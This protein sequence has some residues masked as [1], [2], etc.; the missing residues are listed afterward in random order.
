M[1]QADGQRERHGYVTHVRQTSRMSLKEVPCSRLMSSILDSMMSSIFWKKVG[2]ENLSFSSNLSMPTRRSVMAVQNAL[3]QFGK[4]EK[5]R[6]KK[7]KTKNVYNNNNNWKK[8]H[9][10]A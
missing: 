4:K 6:K 10:C 3:E 5:K 7:K 1:A 9:P 8:K 2:K